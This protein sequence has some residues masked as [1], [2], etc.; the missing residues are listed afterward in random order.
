MP[1]NTIKYDKVITRYA[2]C[3]TEATVTQTNIM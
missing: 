3:I 2:Y 1:H